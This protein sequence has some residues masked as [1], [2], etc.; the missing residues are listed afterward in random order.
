M[1]S[2]N[3]IAAELMSIVSEYFYTDTVYSLSPRDAVNED[4][5]SHISL[6]HNYWVDTR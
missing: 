1:T 3:K 2:E 5:F 6:S 4:V